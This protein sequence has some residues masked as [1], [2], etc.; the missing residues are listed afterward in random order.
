MPSH[1]TAPPARRRTRTRALVLLAVLALL[2]L[3]G[4]ARVQVALAVQP[5]DT[6]DGTIVVATPAGAPDG[7]GPQLAVPADLTDEVELSPYDQDGFVGTRAAFE[8]LTFA[9]VSQLNLLGGNASGRANL[10]LRR[11]GERIAVQGRAD[12]TTM[13]VDRADVRLAMSFPGEVVESDGETDGGTVTWEFVPGEVSQINASV[14]S[15]DPNAPS[16][17]GWSLLLAGLVVV[18]AGA[19]VLLARRDRNPPIRR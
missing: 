18:A 14:I 9:Q 2:A 15:T 7:R 11:V 4:C 19:A 6:V 8:N 3:T 1:H 17:L 13:P 5:D 10:E 16:I 12:L